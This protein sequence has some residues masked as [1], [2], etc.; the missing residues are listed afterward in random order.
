MNEQGLRTE[1]LPCKV[2]SC[3]NQNFFLPGVK[4]KYKCHIKKCVVQC[5]ISDKAIKMIQAIFQVMY[6][7][8]KSNWLARWSVFGLSMDISQVYAQCPFQP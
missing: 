7:R 6:W 8:R 2:T 3:K 5:R 1:I 4:Y